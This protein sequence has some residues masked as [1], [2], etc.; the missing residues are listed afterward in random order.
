MFRPAYSNPMLWPTAGSSHPVIARSVSVAFWPVVT[1]VR[2]AG[3]RA[4]RGRRDPPAHDLKKIIRRIVFQP[5][6]F[7]RRVVECDPAA[8]AAEG[9]D[10]LLVEFPA[11]GHQEMRLVARGQV[12]YDPPHVVLQVRVEE[13]H[14]PA[15]ALGREALPSISTRALAGRK[16]SRG[17]SSL[18]IELIVEIYEVQFIGARV[19]AV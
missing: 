13:I 5:D 6:D 7:D 10:A 1:R 14:R 8:A 9:L 2:Q 19:S 3:I 18:F 12:A 16:G 15:D 17:C 4:S 11:A